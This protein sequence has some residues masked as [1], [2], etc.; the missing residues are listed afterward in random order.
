MARD[1]GSRVLIEHTL[2]QPIPGVHVAQPARGFRYSVDAFWLAGF[3]LELVP[4]GRALDLCTGSGIVAY[5]LAANGLDTQGV[6]IQGEWQELWK[7]SCAP[8]PPA[9]QIAD[10]R[11]LDLRVDL[12]T[13]NPPYRPA[14]TGPLPSSHLKA[15]AH[16]ELNGTLA[17]LTSAAA[18][19]C[20]DGWRAFIVPRD[21]VAELD[22]PTRRLDI[23]ERRT[24][25][26][27]GPGEPWSK[28]ITEADAEQLVHR[29]RGLHAHRD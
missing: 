25:V 16:V 9:L 7:H 27:W 1:R 29:A 20:P 12:I 11:L 22:A 3:A 8:K 18:R 21:R 24:L 17:E 13:C 2:E 14:N 28:A 4:A 19:C 23:G 5:L 10:A 26:A 15:A 6:D